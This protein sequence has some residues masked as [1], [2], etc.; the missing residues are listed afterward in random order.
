LRFEAV[1]QSADENEG[2]CDHS[3]IMF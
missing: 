1:A 3:A 2:S